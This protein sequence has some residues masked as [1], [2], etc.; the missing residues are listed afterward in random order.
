[1]TTA[2]EMFADALVAGRSM[3]E[4]LREMKCHG[5]TLLE[6]IKTAR[7]LFGISFG[8]AR[9][10]VCSHP[11]WR[12]TAIVGTP[13]HEELINAFENAEASE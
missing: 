12:D 5:L 9:Q 11:D 6:A 7:E 13:L 2:T 3:A 1:M 10:L 8:E 4:L